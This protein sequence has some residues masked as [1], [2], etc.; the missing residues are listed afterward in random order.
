[1]HALH[2][3]MQ[4]GRL[5]HGPTDAT[6]CQ[7]HQIASRRCAHRHSITPCGKAVLIARRAVLSWQ[8]SLPLALC[9]PSIH[10]CPRMHRFT[11][12]AL[13]C[14]VSAQ[15][16]K[17]QRSQHGQHGHEPAVHHAPLRGIEEGGAAEKRP[18]TD[19]HTH[20]DWRPDDSHWLAGHMCCCMAF[21]D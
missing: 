13:P 1:M 9:V 4:A 10:P 3:D 5:L 21:I 20:D 17:R 7:V 14:R 18:Q 2:M 12:A 15:A 6:H 16:A 8:V 11:P 19:T